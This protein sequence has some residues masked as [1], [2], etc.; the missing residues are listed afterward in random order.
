MVAVSAYSGPGSFSKNLENLRCWK[1]I[2]HPYTIMQL[3][4]ISV[5]H[6]DWKNDIISRS[7]LN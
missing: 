3:K 4:F 6:P 5:S 2:K 7:D 1:H